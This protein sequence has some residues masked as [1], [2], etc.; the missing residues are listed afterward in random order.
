MKVPIDY[1]GPGNQMAIYSTGEGHPDV[2][3]ATYKPKEGQMNSGVPVFDLYPFGPLYVFFSGD[4]ESVCFIT[5]C[6]LGEN[7]R[8]CLGTDG[9]GRDGICPMRLY[10]WRSETRELELVRE[11]VPCGSVLLADGQTLAWPRPGE[12]CIGDPADC[13]KTRCHAVPA[14]DAGGGAGK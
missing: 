3:V 10:V 6:L 12:V 13:M 4:A 11:D 2:T 9:E 7:E 1:P 14:E 8:P 5:S